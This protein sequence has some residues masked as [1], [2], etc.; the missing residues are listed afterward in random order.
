MQIQG[1]F[2]GFPSKIVPCLGWCPIMTRVIVANLVFFF[3]MLDLEIPSPIIHV[4]GGVESEIVRKQVQ[5]FQRPCPQTYPAV[6]G[7]PPTFWV[8]PYQL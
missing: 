5:R 8:G 3:N 4:I 1:D 2:Q 6:L 7:G